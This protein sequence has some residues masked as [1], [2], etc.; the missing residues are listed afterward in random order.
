MS[1]PKSKKEERLTFGKGSS[2]LAHMARMME[3]H[4]DELDEL[5]RRFGNANK[6][7]PGDNQRDGAVNIAA[8]VRSKPVAET[9]P[10]SSMPAFVSVKFTVPPDSA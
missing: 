1:N 10:Q 3:E 7:E 5:E 6:T 9:S 8:P 4:A 2:A